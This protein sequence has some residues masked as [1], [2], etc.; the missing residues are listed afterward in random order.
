MQDALFP[1]PS[2]APPQLKLDIGMREALSPPPPPQLTQL[3]LD[4]GMQEALSP[5]PSPEPTQLKL[6][7]GM[8]EALSPP[9]SPEPKLDFGMRAA[10]SPSSALK[11]KGAFGMRESLLPEPQDNFG[12]QVALSS[13]PQGFT[14]LQK[15]CAVQIDTHRPT[16][17]SE[18]SA[19]SSKACSECH[20]ASSGTHLTV[21]YTVWEWEKLPPSP[22]NSK[23]KSQPTAIAEVE[24]VHELVCWSV[25]ILVWLLILACSRITLILMHQSYMSMQK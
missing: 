24:G 19:S 18:P 25:C 3:K 11:E 5:P 4:F 14:Q 12:M 2:P 13:E 20:I 17:A 6:D 7:F 15:G 1:P 16:E 10:P 8:R 21:I 22:Q 23:K 9:P